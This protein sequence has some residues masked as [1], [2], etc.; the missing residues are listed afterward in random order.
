[1]NDN[2]L[3]RIRNE[4]IGFVF[5][6]FNLLPRAIGAAE[7]RAAAGLR[8]RAGEGSAR[9]REGRARQ[10]GAGLAHDAPAQRAVRRPASAR[11]DRAGAGQQPVD[12]AGRRADRQP[13][14]EDRRRNHGAV[15]AAP[16][17]RQHHRPRHPRSR[18]SRPTRTGRFTSATGRS[19]RTSTSR[20]PDRHRTRRLQ[21]AASGRRRFPAAAASRSND[22]GS[23]SI[24][25]ARRVGI[26]H[27]NRAEQRSRVR[28]RS[29]S[30]TARRVSPISTIFPRYITATRLQ[31]CS[32]SRRSWAMNRYVSVS[33]CC[34]SISSSTTCAWIDTSSADTGFVGDDERR[35]QR[36][37]ARDADALPLAA[38]ELV[39]I[40][41][42]GAPARGRPARTARATRA[43]R[44]AVVAEPV[45]DERLL[46]DVADAHARIERRVRILKDDLHVAPRRAHPAREN[47]E[48]VLAAEQH[49]AEVGSISRRMQRPVVLL[50]LPDSPT[51]PNI[52]P[53]S[54]VK[55][56]SSTALTTEGGREQAL[57]RGR[58]A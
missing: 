54:I 35:V 45:D 26:Q 56:T 13:R 51:R 15:R 49:L 30:R 23:S 4:E 32:T 5:Q 19:R 48:H 43:R 38:A 29:G 33:R 55:L 24:R 17:G 8:R 53:S 40:A 50:P 14:L 52:S 41:R 9:A 25:V 11:R 36:E 46:D 47:A 6:T 58:S 37:R 34:R 44:S 31:M 12:P 42:R 21:I 28:V 1:M 39:R 18:T 27:R 7:R 57:P 20:P 10:G 16:R 3:A 22:A 2:E